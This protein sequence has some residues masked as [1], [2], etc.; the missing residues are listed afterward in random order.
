MIT[1]FI[2]VYVASCA[3]CLWASFKLSY[4]WKELTMYSLIGCL[5]IV[6][7]IL[8]VMLL[9]DWLSDVMDYWDNPLPWR[10]TK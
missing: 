1:A 10:K 2:I 6:N 3:V 8:L 7:T 5:P 9:V 4:T